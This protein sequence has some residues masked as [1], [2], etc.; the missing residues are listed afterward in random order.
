MPVA[1]WLA[2]QLGAIDLE[3]AGDWLG[4]QWD[5]LTGVTQAEA[6]TEAGQLQYQATQ[7]AIAAQQAA[8]QQQRQDLQPFTQFGQGMIPQAQQA[9]AQSQDLYGPGAGDAIMNNPMFQAIQSQVQQDILGNQAAR[10]RVGTGETPMFMQDAALRTGFDILNNE[11]NAQTQRQQMLLQGLGMGQ[12]AAAGQGAAG[13]Q[14]ALQVGNLMGQGANALGA[15][16]VG[17]ANAQAQGTG[18]L[19]NLGTTLA[20]AGLG[21]GFGGVAGAGAGA[22][23]GSSFNFG[24]PSVAENQFGFG[25]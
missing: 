20:T 10:G 24:Q 4:D 15:G 21:G 9:F 23:A 18:N 2:D 1:A 5:N 6:A 16:A 14:S 25:Y 17:A 22:G 13:M 12:S 11:R 8:A 7:D 19:I 3:Q